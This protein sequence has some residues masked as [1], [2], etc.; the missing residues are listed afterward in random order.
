[1][2]V[3]IIVVAWN[4]RKFVYD[5]LKS[6]YDETKG[7]EF[8]VMYV[9]NAS[10]DGTVEMVRAEFPEVRVIENSENMGF[11]KASNQG[12]EIAKGRYVL[13]LNSD[14]VIL[15]NAIVKAVKFADERPDT[16]VV[17]CKTFYPDGTLQRNC[18][19]CPAV[20]NMFLSA[21]YLNKLFPRSRFFGRERMGWWD[22]D[23][24]REVEAVCGCFLLARREAINQVGVMDERY[25][26]YGDDADW[27]HRFR[28]AGWKVMFTPEP[29]II[30]Y[31]G[32]TTKQMAREFRWQLVGSTLIFMRLHR[33]RVSF[34]ASCFLSGF[35]LALRTPYWLSKG[36]FFRK[37]R[38]SAIFNAGTYLLG[39]WYCLTNWR[40]L[41]MK[42]NLIQSVS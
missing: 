14:T 22:L 38:S 27:C 19:R 26:V 31:H 4:V 37:D 33:S 21:T 28:K 5:C 11:I 24:V 12:I 42:P 34:L 16:A 25:F 9:D 7:I 15:E 17:G 1:M 13:L 6:V 29:Q 30:H 32:A 39:A 36:L 41:L 18:F 35:S 10:E 8:E 2:D 20:V 40:K 3:S 23:E